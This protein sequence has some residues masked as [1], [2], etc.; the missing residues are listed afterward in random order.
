[1][2]TKAVQIAPDVARLRA[3][4]PSPL[5]GTGSNSYL[6]FGTGGAVLVDAGPDLPA[7]QSA[8]MAALNGTPLRAILITHPHLDHSGGARAMARQ[9]GA[10]VYSHGPALRHD[11]GSSEGADF[12]HAPD[13]AVQ[14]GEQIT[15]AGL[16]VSVLHTP[17]HM[18]GHLCFGLRDLL[19]SGDHVMGWSTTLVAPPEGDMAAYRASLRRLQAHDFARYLPGHGEVIENPAARLG[20]LIAHRD[21]REAQILAALAQGAATATDLAARIYSGL[22]PALLPA[23]ALNVQAHLIELARAGRVTGNLQGANARFALTS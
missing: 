11:G 12:D 18:H 14:I 5:T 17:G 9:T 13:I 20:E 8:I 6:I 22:A 2:L 1:M 7:H 10:V 16:R 23:A 15:V 3:D 21:Q 4:N 19:F